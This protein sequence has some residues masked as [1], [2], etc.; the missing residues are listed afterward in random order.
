MYFAPHSER[1]ALHGLRHG[2]KLDNGI[3]AVTVD[4]IANY[5]LIINDISNAL[6]SNGFI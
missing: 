3:R 4:I 5:Q 6:Q 1:G 2:K